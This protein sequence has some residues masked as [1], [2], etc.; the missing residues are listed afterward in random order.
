MVLAVA[1]DPGMHS[2]QNE[3]DSRH[4]AMAAKVPMLEP[5]DSAEC[6]DYAK[7]AYEISEQFDTPVV[8]RL[9][10][11]ISHSRSLVEVGER[12]ELEL[13][14]YQK[15]PQKN[16][17]LPAMAQKKHVLVEQRTRDLTE[18]AE[19]SGINR[20]EMNSTKIGVITSGMC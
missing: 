9:T 20:V 8:L 4:Y 7:L 1:H 18:Y 11:R 5:S 2:S 14:P 16:V 10:T 13:K 3:Q 15:N 12:Q 6:K 19:T 17:M